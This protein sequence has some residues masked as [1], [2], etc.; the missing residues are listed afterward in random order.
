[1]GIVHW[2][3]F[4]C[5]HGVANKGLVEKGASEGGEGGS[6]AGVWGKALLAEE[7]A[8]AKVLG[9]EC[10]CRMQGKAGKPV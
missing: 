1:M 6:H 10:G 5:F 7:A 2:V 3:G 8:S 9:Q 4:L